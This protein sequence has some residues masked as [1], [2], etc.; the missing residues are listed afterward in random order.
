MSDFSLKGPYKIDRSTPPKALYTLRQAVLLHAGIEP[1]VTVLA[2]SGEH[3]REGY[4]VVGHVSRQTPFGQGT[5]MGVRISNLQRATRNQVLTA[6]TIDHPNGP[7]FRPM[8]KELDNAGFS[9]MMSGPN[10][11]HGL[12]RDTALPGREPIKQVTRA[13]VERYANVIGAKYQE[14]L[15]S[16][17]TITQRQI[18]AITARYR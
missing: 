6:I 13:E 3:R 11:P 10:A 15:D 18:A 9:L 4:T 12:T 8:C 14:I 5:S 2:I 1:G 17:D 7:G 16:W